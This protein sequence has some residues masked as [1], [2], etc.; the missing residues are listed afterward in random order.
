MENLEYCIEHHLRRVHPYYE[1]TT[2]EYVKYAHDH[3]IMVN[4]WTVDNENDIQRMKD[5]GVDIVISNDVAT[6][7]RVLGK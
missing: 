7:Q 2:P 1:E 4:V 5:C 3:N 6:A